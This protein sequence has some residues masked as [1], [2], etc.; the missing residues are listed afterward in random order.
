MKTI[1]DNFDI[2]DMFEKQMAEFAGSKYAVA[3]DSCTHAIHLCLELEKKRNI[4]EYTITLPSRTYISV[5]M[6]CINA[7]FKIRFKDIDWHDHYFLEPYNIIDAAGCFYKDMFVDFESYLFCISFGSKK[8]FALGKGGMIFTNNYETCKWLKFASFDGRDR[9]K[10]VMEDTF[11]NIGWHYQM[12][13]EIAAQGLIKFNMK[14][15]T[16]S[17]A[18][19]HYYRDISNLPCFKEYLV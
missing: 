14:Q 8:P 7:G 16:E 2:V 18:F 12:I 11:E 6:Q 5:P 4:H 17:S 10:G 3:V 19:F 9:H 13:P 1:I 15:Y